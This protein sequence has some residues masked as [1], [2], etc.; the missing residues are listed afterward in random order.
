M[1]FEFE[2]IER[3]K[4]VWQD[5][6]CLF[7]VVYFFFFPNVFFKPRPVW[8]LT[9]NEGTDFTLCTAGADLVRNG[10][11]IE[12]TF[13]WIFDSQ[14]NDYFDDDGLPLTPDGGNSIDTPVMDAST[15]A[16]YWIEVDD[17]IDF[18]SPEIQPGEVVSTDQYYYYNGAVL[19]DDRTW[20]WR[21]MVKD[22]YGSQTDWVSGGSFSFGV[23]T[24]LKG[25]IKLKG[26]I[27][28]QFP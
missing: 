9:E 2:K 11:A 15:Q 1:E 22:S 23:D 24:V 8:A 5:L 16:S 17:N 27:R 13:L 3:E 21:I 7:F 18:S 20:N 19:T 28:F 10:A 4:S 25:D 12:V 14:Q 6:L 26:N